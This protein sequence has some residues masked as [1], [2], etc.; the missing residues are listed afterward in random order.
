MLI[1]MTTPDGNYRIVKPFGVVLI[2]RANDKHSFRGKVDFWSTQPDNAQID[3]WRRR[4]DSKQNRS[5]L[6]GGP[7]FSSHLSKQKRQWCDFVTMGPSL[8]RVS[9]RNFRTISQF[10]NDLIIIPANPLPQPLCLG[11][12]DRLGTGMRAW[13]LCL[14]WIAARQHIQ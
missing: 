2:W 5:D 9:F 12:E 10:L 11:S 1:R 8:W 3:F 7:L 6:E 13:R 4:N 14:H